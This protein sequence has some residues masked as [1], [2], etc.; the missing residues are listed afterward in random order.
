MIVNL[1]IDKT[2]LVESSNS[3]LVHTEKDYFA[4]YSS[5]KDSIIN[6]KDIRIIS[7][8]A[9]VISWLSNA[10]SKYPKT[11]IISKEISFKELLAKKWNVTYDIEISD[12]Q[13]ISEKLDANINWIENN[14]DMDPRLKV[15]ICKTRIDEINSLCE[16]LY[17]NMVR[18]PMD[19]NDG[20]TSINSLI[21]GNNKAPNME[22]IRNIVIS[23]C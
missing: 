13:I 11:S 14:K 3:I 12:I 7:Y 20:M 6:N 16:E 15:E 2:K 21:Y 4:T 19:E 17:Q 10:F 1:I 8:S 22:E 5:I 18:N 23:D 9:P